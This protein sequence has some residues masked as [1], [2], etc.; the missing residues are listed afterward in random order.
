[1]KIGGSAD[2]APDW[3]NPPDPATVTEVRSD[4]TTLSLVAS[5]LGVSAE[6][7]QKANPQIADPN[8]L[9]AGAELR[10]P[11][12]VVEGAA[13]G[14]DTDSAASAASKRMEG[15]LD[16]AVMRASLGASPMHVT[17]AGGST[18]GSGGITQ[19]PP[20]A[21]PLAADPESEKQK[22]E[23]KAGLSK[24]YNAAQQLGISYEDTV[25]MLHTLA[26]NPP[27]TL[28][29]M[30]KA[31]HLFFMAKD[32]PA[33]D[34]KLVDEA[35][36]RS[37]GDPDYVDAL[38]KLV[39]NPKFDKASTQVKQQWLQKFQSLA[40][41]PDL[42]DLDPEERS[43]ALHA[44]ASDPP[45]SEDKISSTRDV[46]ASAKDLSPADR[47]LFVDGLNRN[48]GDPAYA[49][50]LKKLIEDPK[51]KSLKPAE[52]TAVLSQTKNYANASSVANIDRLLQ[53]N[54]F[55]A[56][57]LGDKQR[58]L[59]V[60]GRLSQYPTGDRKLIDNTLDKL[61]DP[62]SHLKI[63]WVS[64]PKNGTGT[65]WGDRDG[66]TIHMNNDKDFAPA[67]NDSLPEN[68]NTDELA[69]KTLPH[70]VNH[71]LNNDKVAPTFQYFE[72]EYRA[73]YVGFKAEHGRAPTN[74]EAMEQRINWQL[75]PDSVYGKSAIPAMKNPQEAQQFY[76]FLESV[77]GMK[78]NAK[79][80]KD[81]VKSDPAT[82][83]AK[84]SDA[85]APVPSG[86]VD[87]H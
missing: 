74:Q 73:W 24:V 26:G 69:I 16:A 22:E 83:P 58:T 63:E 71:Y 21:I 64:Y 13:T 46:L 41:S 31:L 38:T 79:N 68:E 43:I 61:L 9:T 77:T 6:D 56:Q 67:G 29:K 85:P 59:K 78:V 51:F 86:N 23:M 1:M 45:P 84:K 11:A 57:D 54:W 30:D 33:T 25:S 15:N 39:A 8:Q 48:G 40:K 76:H 80:W 34:R 20:V 70:E 7:L 87:N 14:R 28:Q 66:N 72:A 75:N 35:F 44:L 60:I 55:R 62:N 12:S 19:M 10:L 36:V 53:K 50:N 49:A 3:S 65:T 18:S 4:E 17:P 27:L 37:H 82:W 47:K 52:K 32:L 81:V 5:R 42:K 2:L